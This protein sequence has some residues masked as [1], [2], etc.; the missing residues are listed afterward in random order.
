MIRFEM[1]GKYLLKLG[2]SLHG[3]GKGDERYIYFELFVIFCYFLIL[4]LVFGW[5]AKDDTQTSL[6]TTKCQFPT[7]LE[8]LD[9]VQTAALATWVTSS[10]SLDGSE[11]L[12]LPLCVR[13][14]NTTLCSSAFLVSK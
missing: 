8:T 5:P 12:F 4:H 7:N 1:F 13:H 11:S 2:H 10:K 9:I 14:N 3:E 6:K